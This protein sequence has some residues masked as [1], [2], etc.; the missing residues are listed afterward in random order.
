MALDGDQMGQEVVNAIKAYTGAGPLPQDAQI[1]ALWQEICKAI[2][3]HI[4]TNGHATGND[5]NGDSHNL[6]IV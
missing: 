2:V 4:Q 6:N 3:L 1:L 5:S